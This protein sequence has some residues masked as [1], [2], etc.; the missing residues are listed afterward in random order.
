[1]QNPSLKLDLFKAYLLKI[2]AIFGI[3]SARL[4]VTERVIVYERV[5]QGRG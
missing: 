2:T 1:M 4:L 3:M 5:G